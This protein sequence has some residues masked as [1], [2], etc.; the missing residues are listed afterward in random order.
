[1]ALMARSDT[2]FHDFVVGFADPLSRLAYLLTDGAVAS[3]SASTVDALAQ[4]R[5]QWREAETTGSPESL[6]VEALVGRLPRP[7]RVPH[8]VPN[9]SR[10]VDAPD[11]RP[12]PRT[13]DTNT[14]VDTATEALSVGEIDAA[15]SEVIWNSWRQLEPRHRVPLVFADLSV[16]SR[17]LAELDVPESFGAA[18]RSAAIADETVRAIRADLAA[19]PRTRAAVAAM[20]D[21]AIVDRLSR[22]LRL[23]GAE[24]TVP[25]DPYP[26]VTSRT[27]ELRR[28]TLG[29]VGIAGV[30]VVAAAL[31]VA[32]FSGGTREG[33]KATTTA[34]ADKPRPVVVPADQ[35]AAGSRLNV[36]WPT[37]GNAA[38]DTTLIDRLKLMF[39]Q[40]HPEASDNVQVLVL[41]DTSAFRI[42]YLTANS[43]N[44]VIQSWFSG[45]VGASELFE[46]EFNFGGSVQADSVIATTVTNSV[47][48]TQLVVIA[49][50]TADN[51]TLATVLPN[52]T[53]PRTYE[54]LTSADGVAFKEVPAA[55]SATFALT[56]RIDGRDVAIDHVPDV[57]IGSNSVE[58]GTSAPDLLADALQAANSWTSGG[59]PTVTGQRVALWG[60]VD[61]TGNDIIAVRIRTASVA[62]GLLIDWSGAPALDGS[63]DPTIRHVEY[64]LL[65]PNAPDFP[66]AFRYGDG[67]VGVVVP[68]PTTFTRAALVINGNEGPQVTIDGDGFASMSLADAGAPADT[69]AQIDVFDYTGNFLRVSLPTQTP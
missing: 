2:E 26:M 41:A 53:A 37:R 48:Q 32:T 21:V 27:R 65:S 55:T 52:Q 66:L 39:A 18:R 34:H 25:S 60:G 35:P 13:A 19:D 11:I 59:G 58:R 14:S 50:P 67:L 29:V 54:P 38:D 43:A 57:Q 69:P 7:W 23:R 1:M 68:I 42:A 12:D 10:H 45:P 16:A 64:F 56:V 61:A 49:R 36:A 33:K 47:G 17:R 22:V 20:N 31:A 46:G 6:A 62:D 40:A 28:R 44:G 63:A 24:A 5:R 9:P 51:M 15:V 8:H 30:L 4:V 3:S